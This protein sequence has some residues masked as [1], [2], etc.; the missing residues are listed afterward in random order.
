M[1]GAVISIDVTEIVAQWADGSLLDAGVL[2]RTDQPIRAVFDTKETEG[3]IQA[4]LSVNYTVPNP[5]IPTGTSSQPT[6]LDFTAPPVIIDEPGTY[7]LDRDWQIDVPNPGIG[8]MLDIRANWV[9]VDLH[10]FEL[11]AAEQNL[12]HLVEVS[13]NGVTV[14]N[15]RLTANGDGDRGSFTTVVSSTGRSTTLTQL[16]IHGSPADFAVVLQA[17][18]TIMYSRVG[19]ISA[20]GGPLVIRFNIMGCSSLCLEV[21]GGGTITD[22]TISSDLRTAELTVDG[23]LIARNQIR[24]FY[25]YG[26]N[27]TGADNILKDNVIIA[28][29]AGIKVNGTR[30]ILVEN[31][32][33]GDVGPAD[34]GIVFLAKR[35]LLRRQPSICHGVLR[36]RHND[37]S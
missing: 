14:T 18:G 1:I 12:V 34:F 30:N 17:G 21:S 3:G 28:S 27:I 20:T 4:S 19:D 33:A 25:S 32:I 2:L 13:G 37:T 15:G 26:L 29:D 9:T 10:G 5:N 6:V 16:Q 24:S 22:N 11:A 31:A 23:S 7:I 8:P 35:E 36:D